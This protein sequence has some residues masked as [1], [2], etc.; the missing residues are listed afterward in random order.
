MLGDSLFVCSLHLASRS[1]A[2]YIKFLQQPC[3]LRKVQLHA[4]GQCHAQPACDLM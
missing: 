3:V 4:Y 1:A 2:V